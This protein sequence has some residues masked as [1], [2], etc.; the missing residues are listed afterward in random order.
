MIVQSRVKHLVDSTMG[1]E[2]SGELH[3][4]SAVSI[5]AQSERLE[6]TQNEECIKRRDACSIHLLD[7]NETHAVDQLFSPH[8]RSGEKIPMASQI[9]GG[10]VHHDVGP[11]RNGLLQVGS[12]VGIVDHEQGALPATGS[13]QRRDVD[14]PHVGV[15]GRLGEYAPRGRRYCRGDNGRIR[16]VGEACLHAEAADLMVKKSERTTVVGLVGDHLVALLQQCPD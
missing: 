10:R 13:G 6:A 15:R 7:S 9:F 4:R 8:H 5:H 3:G 1:P 11:K 2:I 16:K 14:D 12:A